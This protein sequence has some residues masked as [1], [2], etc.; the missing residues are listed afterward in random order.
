MQ[1]I[2]DPIILGHNPF[3]GVDHLSRG[4]IPSRQARLSN[5]TTVIEQIR[6]ASQLG[7]RGLMLPSGDRVNPLLDA[8]RSEP[9]LQEQVHIYPQIPDAGQL[10]SRATERGVVGAVRDLLQEAGVRGTS[11]MAAGGMQTLISGDITRLLRTLLDLELARFDGFQAPA[12]FLHPVF[13]DLALGLGLE[14]PLRTYIDHLEA[15]TAMRPAF[16]TLNLPLLLA[17]FEEWSLEPPLV[18]SAVN[19]AGYRMNPS[20]ACCERTLRRVDG[21]IVAMMILAGG[22]LSPDSAI[23]YALQFDSVQS[24][25]IGAS[26]PAHLRESCSLLRERLT[27]R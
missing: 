11:A 10:S 20:Q 27:V 16:C 18:M 26:T 15:R 6:L 1:G 24:V 2:L 22:H 21:P 25:V 9:A 5:L 12:I 7:A 14:M 23:D 17:R 13:T 3:F 19:A 8:L 4:R